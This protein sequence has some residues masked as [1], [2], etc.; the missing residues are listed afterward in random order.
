MEKQFGGKEDLWR[1]RKRDRKKKI[2][3][4]AEKENYLP[5]CLCIRKS[6]PESQL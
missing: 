1:H 4:K 3:T 2:L 5:S 6:L